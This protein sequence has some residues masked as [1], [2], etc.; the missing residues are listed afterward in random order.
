MAK[1]RFLE[2]AVHHVFL[3]PKLPQRDDGDLEKE[4]KLVQEY[5]K[6]LRLF[7]SLLAEEERL[8]WMSCIK[9]VSKMLETR[10]D[11]GYLLAETLDTSLESIE[12]GGL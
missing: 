6:A 11:N 5:L 4:R 7:Q 8:P 9:M 3:P 10:Q 12:D 2:Y 1:D